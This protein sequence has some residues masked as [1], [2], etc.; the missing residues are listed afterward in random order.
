M[1][2]KIARHVNVGASQTERI[3]ARSNKTRQSEFVRGRNPESD[4]SSQGSNR[5]G[6][7]PQLLERNHMLILSRKLKETIRV[8]E[9]EI[10][11]SEIRGNK[12]KLAINAPDE[13]KVLRVELEEVGA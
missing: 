7:R 9:A 11:I 12:V 8:G 10:T 1:K 6:M 2:R 4:R 5:R 13:V 3:G